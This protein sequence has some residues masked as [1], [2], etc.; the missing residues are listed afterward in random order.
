MATWKRTQTDRGT[1][2]ITAGGRVVVYQVFWQKPG[3]TNQASSGWAIFVD[4]E[5]HSAPAARTAIAAMEHA[6]Q[7]GTW[8]A[9]QQRMSRNAKG[10]GSGRA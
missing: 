7:P 9:I 8:K 3:F 1:E 6:E 5:R 10:D 2:Y 4:E